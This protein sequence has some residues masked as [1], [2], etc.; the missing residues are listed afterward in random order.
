[1]MSS[2]SHIKFYDVVTDQTVESLEKLSPPQ[3]GYDSHFVE[4]PKPK[5]LTAKGRKGVAAYLPALPI[6]DIPYYCGEGN[7]PLIESKELDG[8]FI[9]NEGSNPTGNFKDRESAL[10]LAYAAAQGYKNLAI[11]SSGNAA[12]SAALYARLY[13]IRLTAYVPHRTPK[14]K[15]NMIDLFGAQTH[16]VGDTYEETYHYLLENLPHGT[17]NITPGVFTLRSEGTKTMAY[18]I[19]EQLGTVPDYLVCPTANGSG[20]SSIYHGFAELKRWGFTDRI[21]A[22]VSVQIKGADPINQAIESGDWIKNVPDAVDSQCEAIVAEESYCSP[23][24]VYAVK[25]SGGLGISVTDHQV[26]DGLRYAIDHEGI[27]PEL[28]SASVFAGLMENEKLFTK[29]GK[30]TVL[31]N[32]ATGLKEI[33]QLRDILNGDAIDEKP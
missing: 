16:F 31:I 20:L 14:Y 30:K 2:A 12:L 7:T 3:P 18:E 4:V 22:M 25:Q 5:S 9:K 24:A 8:V 32:T 6:D 33:Q 11:V 27:F 17:I 1:M 28:S 26:V 19:W 10:T 15:T 13:G 21:P 29:P 23:K